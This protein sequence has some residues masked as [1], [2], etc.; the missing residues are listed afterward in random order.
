MPKFVRTKDGALV[1]S[2]EIVEIRRRKDSVC[3][4][5]TKSGESH[6]VAD[7]SYFVA[8]L[9]EFYSSTTIPAHPGYSVIHAFQ[10]EDGDDRWECLLLPVVGWSILP[11]DDDIYCGRRLISVPLVAGDLEGIKGSNLVLPDGRVIGL[12]GG[13]FKNVGDWLDA[14]VAYRTKNTKRKKKFCKS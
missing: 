1:L 6:L 9:A 13:V 4:I 8:Y 12:N 14:E 5:I 2:S 7:D 3:K 10:A 11:V